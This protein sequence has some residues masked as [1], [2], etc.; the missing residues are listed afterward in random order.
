M[1]RQEHVAWCKE[2]AL[3]YLDSGDVSEVY[4]SMASD[5]GKH[6]ETADHPATMIGMQ[7]MLIG[8]LSTAPEM[9]EFILG[10][11]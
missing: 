8:K 7:L 5:L 1:N 2:R 9:R 3:V 6:D 11:N 4:A 10:F